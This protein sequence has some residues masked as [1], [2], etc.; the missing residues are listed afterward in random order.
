MNDSISIK[1]KLT[2][3]ALCSPVVAQAPAPLAP[4]APAL[5]LR[6]LAGDG[7]DVTGGKLDLAEERKRLR[8]WLRADLPR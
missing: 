3:L 2:A 6:I 8:A 7:D 5:E 4:A 1:L